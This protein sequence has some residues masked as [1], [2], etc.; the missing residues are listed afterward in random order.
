MRSYNTQQH[1]RERECNSI[2]QF[3]NTERVQCHN[4]RHEWFPI[5]LYKCLT[6][7]RNP[8]QLCDKLHSASK[9]RGWFEHYFNNNG[10]SDSRV[11]RYRGSNRVGTY[12]VVISGTSESLR[13]TATLTVHVGKHV[14]P[15]LTVPSTETVKQLATISFL[16]NATDQSIPSPTTLTLSATNLPPGASFETNQG[17][18]PV[19]GIFSWTPSTTTAPGTYNINFSVTDGFSSTQAEIVITVVATN[20]L[21]VIIAPG[22]RNT[23]VGAT[24][25][26][27]VTASDPTG[28]GGTVTL[29][30]TGL[31]SNMAFDP[32]TGSF[33]FTPNRSQSGETFI[34]N[35]TATDSINPS[36][37]STQTVMIH[38]ENAGNTPGSSPGST[39]S[40]P[41]TQPPPEVSGS[42]CLT[43]ALKSMILAVAWFIFIGAV[44][45]VVSSVAFL[46]IRSRAK[47]LG[48][49]LR[50][51]S[52]L[53]TKTLRS[54]DNPVRIRKDGKK[55]PNHGTKKK[56][57]A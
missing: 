9:G 41:S 10:E 18:V 34:V 24:L 46:T 4:T 37:T 20:V 26:F 21:P 49:R 30:A 56:H 43:C 53:F 7:F 27:A 1:Y 2:L 32:T 36:W 35:F 44:I 51:R 42:G 33:S 40:T 11:Q 52:R 6:R 12:I 16:V 54:A 29:S 3:K 31:A 55:A 28:S 39:P 38:V 14:P 8:T 47:L 50:L 57:R 5:T 15:I 19:S 45:G 13:R 25:D 22:P 23:T 17:A 48:G